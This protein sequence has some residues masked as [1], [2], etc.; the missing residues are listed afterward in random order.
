M[1]T[2]PPPIM[3][4]YY[5]DEKSG[6]DDSSA[7]GQESAP[8]ASL[9]YAYITNDGQGTYQVR[10]YEEGKEPEYAPASKAGTKKAVNALAAH[11]KKAGKA[12]ELAIR[13]KK[14]QADR[15]KVL[16]ESKKIVI[17]ED[18]SLPAPKTIK[19]DE[20]EGVTLHK[21]GSEEK[22]TRVRVVGMSNH[23]AREQWGVWRLT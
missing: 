2:P 19:L 14:E 22:G 9:Q 12:D 23:A 5:I 20:V 4:T 15:E 8:Y 11:K 16:E 21:E 7:T 10:K 3:A 17:T 18:K 1:V 13:E 6:K